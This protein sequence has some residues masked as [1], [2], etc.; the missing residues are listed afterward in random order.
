MIATTVLM[1]TSEAHRAVI[2]TTVLVRSTPSFRYPHDNQLRLLSRTSIKSGEREGE[3]TTLGH[4]P[5]KLRLVFIDW[6]DNLGDKF[7]QNLSTKP[8]SNIGLKSVGSRR[9]S[10][11]RRS[12][13][14]RM[15]Y[16]PDIKEVLQRNMEIPCE[17]R[18]LLPSS[19]VYV[20]NS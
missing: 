20:T 16:S 10:R 11:I 2:A 5:A 13:S 3:V 14:R 6:N 7:H 19:A 8:P 18:S 9:N 15:S 4:S 12:P 1:S 17:N